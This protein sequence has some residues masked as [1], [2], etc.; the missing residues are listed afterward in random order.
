MRMASAIVLLGLPAFCFYGALVSRKGRALFI[1]TGV[2]LTLAN[3][4]ANAFLLAPVDS[5]LQSR[6]FDKARA[7]SLL[8]ADESRVRDVLGKPW[9]EH[10]LDGQFKS[11]AYAPCKVCVRSYMQP[12]LVYL[13]GDKVIGFR[14]GERVEAVRD[15]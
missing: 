15:R 14:A 10:V 7:S 12:F 1:F 8:G 3:P 11:L 9:R 6:L 5:A 2:G 4:L 13:E